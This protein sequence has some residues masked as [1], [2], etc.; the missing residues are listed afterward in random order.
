MIRFALATSLALAATVGAQSPLET[1]FTNPA[2]GFVVTNVVSPI[3]ALFDLTVTDPAGVAIS[4]FDLEVNTT[5][6]TNGQMGVWLTSNGGTHV[7]FHQDPTVWT[8]A[9]TANTVHTGGRVSFQL[10]S[11]IALLPG[12][13]GVALH[14]IEANPV[15]HGGAVS[16][17]LPQTYSTNEMTVDLSACRLRQSDAVDPFAGTS[18]GFSP[19]QVAVAVHYSVGT[20]S[21][22]FTA[23]PTSGVSPLQ[24]QFSS[25]VSSGAGIQSY[26][27]DFDGDGVSDSSLANPSFTFG[28]G[29]YT[30]SLT[31]TE[32]GGATATA[33]KADFIVTDVVEPSFT[34][35]IIAPNTVQFTDTTVPTPDTWAWD[36]DNDGVVDSTAQN[37][38]H[39]FANGC[40]EAIVSLTASLA[41][42]PQANLVRPIAVATTIESTFVGGLVTTTTA[43]S[44]ANYF[45]LSVTNPRG[46]SLCSMHVNA[47]VVAGSPVT[48]N[49]YQTDDTHVGKTGDALLWRLVGTATVNSLGTGERTFCQF[50]PPIYLPAGDFGI[51]MEHIGASPSYTNLG[52]TQVYGNAD[53]TMTAGT[54]QSEP[55]FDP[56][57]ATF[58]P[59]IANVALH[60]STSQTTGVAGYG[61]L[62]PGCAGSLGIVATRALSQPVVGGTLDIEIS[63]LPIDLGVLALG[64]QQRVPPTDLASVGLPGCF[65]YASGELPATIMGTGNTANYSLQLPS[66]TSIIGVQVFT[67]PV[68]VDPGFNPASLTVGDAA[69]AL[70]GM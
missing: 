25:L 68:S 10:S 46:I 8:L 65:F 32:N 28:C 51:C 37:P 15:Y 12:T 44:A 58:S 41:C 59:R 18:A 30:V 43:T 22:D 24:V 64:L 40:D 23:T 7:G 29:S 3:T 66:S 62:A 35:E 16:P 52:G 2:P 60:F 48:V 50:S 6:G 53:L 17:T 70:I 11:P 27:W 13:Y 20:F 67:Q 55:V 63:G 61:F 42:G 21:V 4:Q 5:H 38:T 31:V 34:N 54:S 19:R 69:V 45:D 47:T 26:D 14:C 56:A 1:T 33:T 57:S 39:V 49:I 36:F 9:A